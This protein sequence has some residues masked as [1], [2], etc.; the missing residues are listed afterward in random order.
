MKKTSIIS[1]RTEVT[2]EIFVDLDGVLA[3][4]S[5]GM[6]KAVYEVY[7]EVIAHNEDEYERNKEYQKKM[8]KACWEYQSRGGELWYE[9]DL[10]PDAMDLWN[11]IKHHNPQI[12]SATG[13][14][15]FGA[16][17]QKRRWVPEKFGDGIVVNL[18]FSASEKAIY[19]AP[20]RILIDDKLK[21]IN[22]W[23]EA[24][25]IGVHHTSAVDSI[26]KLKALGI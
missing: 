16:E 1:K 6:S 8:W 26:R 3:A 5:K 15:K 10:M 25:G 19:A 4:F 24:G 12:L 7:G 18:T 22:P 14:K 23:E 13:H 11:Y 21:A 9:L 2:F 20:N 17:G